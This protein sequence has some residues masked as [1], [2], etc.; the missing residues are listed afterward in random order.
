M[1]LLNYSIKARIL[2]LLA[3]VLAILIAAPVPRLDAQKPREET[4]SVTR[5]EQSDSDTGL[6]R[7]LEMHG[8]A[9][10]TDD[11][12]DIKSVSEGGW[13]I[14]EERRDRQSYRYEVRRDSGGQLM[15][16][17]YVN[18]VSKPIDANGK[19]WLAKFVLDAVRQ[20]GFDAEKRVR[21]I[22]AQRG[23]AGVLAEIDQVHGDYAKRI[24]YEQLL[25]QAEILMKSGY[26]KYLKTIINKQQQ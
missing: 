24:Y 1:K 19:A 25:K 17:F 6:M 18:G 5:W 7:R 3:S 21:T 11:Y 16:M 8:K 2:W 4:T 10:F 23:V 20:G 26:G 9:E 15:R 14:I 13:V 22:L 12:T